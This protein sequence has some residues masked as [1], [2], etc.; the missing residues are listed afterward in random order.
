MWETKNRAVKVLSTYHRKASGCTQ[1]KYHNRESTAI[2]SSTACPDNLNSASAKRPHETQ[3]G[4]PMCSLAAACAHG[5][6]L[7]QHGPCRAANPV[8]A[9]CTFPGTQNQL[10]AAGPAAASLTGALRAARKPSWLR[11]RP[12]ARYHSVAAASPGLAGLRARLGLGFLCFFCFF[13][14]RAARRLLTDVLDQV[15]PRVG[16]HGVGGRR[17]LGGGG[18]ALLSG[19]LPVGRGAASGGALGGKGGAG[20]GRRP[21]RA[22]RRA[23]APRL[24]PLA[25][26]PESSWSRA[27]AALSAAASSSMAGGGRRLPSGSGSG[28]SGGAGL[29]EPGR[30]PR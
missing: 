16:R 15:P 13:G 9:F 24:P 2:L 28:S 4:N 22:P 18:G 19:G 23:L 26:L 6:Q 14:E 5:Q 21:L 29:G 17:H 10:L 7:P 30:L 12:K 20:G 11:S 27:Q 25:H 1:Q 3:L 8:S